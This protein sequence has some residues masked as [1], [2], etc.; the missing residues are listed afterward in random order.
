MKLRIKK[1]TAYPTKASAAITIRTEPVRTAEL[2]AMSIPSFLSLSKT[3]SEVQLKSFARHSVICRES[4]T[5]RRYHAGLTPAVQLV[6]RVDAALE[7]GEQCELTGGLLDRGLRRD[8]AQQRR[9]APR[10]SLPVACAL[11]RRRAVPGVKVVENLLL[12]IL[13]PEVAE[14][15][16]AGAACGEHHVPLR[17][18][19]PLS[20]QPR[21]FE[22]RGQTTFCA[23]SL[24]KSKTWSVPGFH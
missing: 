1:T 14:T 23:I 18:L 12:E 8:R 21:R 5:I 9:D 7:V 3:H 2:S 15:D 17:E 10:F 16:A 19:G 11:D 4:R 20:E 6:E 22:N 13:Q 24:R